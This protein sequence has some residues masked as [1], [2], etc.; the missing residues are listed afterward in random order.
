V[1]S[2]VCSGL[3]KVELQASAQKD[4]DMALQALRGEGG[5][6][7][8]AEARVTGYRYLI[9]WRGGG[10]RAWGLRD[11]G[12]TMNAGDYSVNLVVQERRGL[13]EMLA[14]QGRCS[15]LAQWVTAL[16]RLPAGAAGLHR[17]AAATA[18]YSLTEPTHSP[19]STKPDYPKHRVTPLFIS[20]WDFVLTS[21]TV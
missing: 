17:C 15:S 10:I 7:C 13:P 12:R 8:R 6:C 2:C 18:C 5:R 20:R 3:F 21:L 19:I 11:P 9:F 1:S 14:C 16:A 4:K